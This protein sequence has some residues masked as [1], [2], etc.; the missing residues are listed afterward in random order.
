MIRPTVKE[1]YDYNDM[2]KHINEKFHVY[3]NDFAGRYAFQQS[4]GTRLV[5]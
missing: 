1:I 3:I 4:Q 2:E 5:S